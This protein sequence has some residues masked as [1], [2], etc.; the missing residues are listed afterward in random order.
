MKKFYTLA[1]C[2]I[3]FSASAQTKFSE[4]VAGHVY[5]LSIPDYMSKTYQLN[6]NAE[7]QYQDTARVTYVI[8]IEDSKESL[9]DL[10]TSFN[11]AQEFYDYFI[12]DYLVDAENRKVTEPIA[13]IANGNKCIQSEFTYTADGLDLYFLITI[14]ESKTYFYKILCWT[15]LESKD[16]YKQDFV[17][18][19]S[20]LRD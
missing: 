20:S 14:V 19:S 18:I 8:G 7:I 9:K 6:D 3:I 15:L 4:K 17:K 2:F 13:F 5:Y 11:N 12:K 16:K 1:L 10:G